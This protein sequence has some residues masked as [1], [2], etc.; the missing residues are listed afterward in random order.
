MSYTELYR[1]EPI[2]NKLYPDD[3]TVFRLH[4]KDP[5]HKLWFVLDNNLVLPEYLVEFE[6]IMK[7]EDQNKVADFGDKIAILENPE[8]EFISA[9][10]IVTYK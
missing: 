1:K 4:E 7:S 2:D 3:C 10:N 9:K 6:Y 5:K 8:D